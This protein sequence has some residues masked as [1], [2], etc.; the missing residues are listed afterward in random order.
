MDASSGQADARQ[1]K[2][3]GGND[4]LPAVLIGNPAAGRFA[5]LR[6]RQGEMLRVCQEF[7]WAATIVETGP[8]PGSAERLTRDAVHAGARLVIACGGDGTVHGVLQA[9][10]Q[11]ET[12]LGVLP[13]G[14]ANALA[15]NLTLPLEPVSALHRLLGYRAHRIPLGWAE[16][17][18]GG[19]WFCVMAGAGPDGML[20]QA[21]VAGAAAM[22][23]AAKARFGRSA[24]YGRAAR[25]LLTRRFE[26]FC[27]ECR[28]QDRWHRHTAIG[29]MASRVPDLGGLFRGL[30]AG[31]RLHHGRLQVQL[32]RG[33]ALLSLPS[34][35]AAAH[36]RLSAWNPLVETV[37]VDELRCTALR[38]HALPHA[39][40]DG[41]PA[42]ELPLT[43]RV[44][45]DALWLLCPGWAVDTSQCKGLARD[46]AWR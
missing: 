35:M 42:G 36:L 13:F 27:V 6:A 30:T 2:G 44:V 31:S 46:T 18:M 38:G 3:F 8:E 34:W 23:A 37:D 15:R 40:V 1:V 16:T 26:P 24:Y 43:L 45:P 21:S 14:T 19:R 41:E 12:A 7:G 28:Q 32:L 5:K 9:L 20:V 4:V 22:S 11:T 33:P 25:L 39:Q 10:A 29:V 17:G